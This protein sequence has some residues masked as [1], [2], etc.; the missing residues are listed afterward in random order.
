MSSKPK[1][2]KIT[3]EEAAR[4]ETAVARWNDY[5]TR[6]KPYEDQYM[7]MVQRTE[8]DH[9][10]ARGAAATAVTQAFSPVRK[11]FEQ[12]LFQRGAK[13]GS[14]AHV[15]GTGGMAVD[16]ANVRGV[17]TGE[18]HGAVQAQHLQ[19]LQNVVR[20]GQGQSNLAYA[21][22]GNLASNAAQDANF[23]AQLAAQRRAGVGEAV[24]T[25][26]GAGLSYHMHNRNAQTG[27]KTPAMTADPRYATA[28]SVGTPSMIPQR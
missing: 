4:A 10:Q 19:G 21:G 8:G 23:R 22:L 15:M 6:L 9:A 1:E 18:A 17:G 7:Q 20:L 27:A 25:A 5:Q 3:A 24:G 26:M 11:Q 2:P 28:S 13:P 14:G 16:E 12:N